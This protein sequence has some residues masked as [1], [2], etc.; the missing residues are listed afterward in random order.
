MTVVD[1]SVAVK[2]LI[3]EPGEMA[4][5][6]LLATR[7]ELVAP[8]LIRL[9]V[10]AAVLRAYREARL[11]EADARDTLGRW[12]RILDAAFVRLIPDDALFSLAVEISVRVRHA[13]PDCLYY[14]AAQSTRM[15]LVTSDRAMYGRAGNDIQAELLEGSP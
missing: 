15:T 4:A 10:A 7:R 6:E 12:Q 11:S 8:A 14:A 3:P 13:L 5:K 2:W 1:A 9:E